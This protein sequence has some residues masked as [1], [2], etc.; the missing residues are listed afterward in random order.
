MAFNFDNN[1]NLYLCFNQK[2]CFLILLLFNC[3]LA[4]TYYIHEQRQLKLV[5]NATAYTKRIY[6]NLN[7]KQNLIK[8]IQSMKFIRN[9]LENEYNLDDLLTF[10]DIAEKE[11]SFGL[12]CTRKINQPQMTIAI[13]TNSNLTINNNITEIR[14]WNL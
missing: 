14:Y 12:R 6:T 3:F 4:C 8:I 2:R 7:Q 9:I 13:S 1:H 5:Q 11:F 10:Y